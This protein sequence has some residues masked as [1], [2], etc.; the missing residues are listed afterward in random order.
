MHALALHPSAF[1]LLLEVRSFLESFLFE[2]VQAY[3]QVVLLNYLAELKGFPLFYRSQLLSAFF[4]F[5]VTEFNDLVASRSL[6][7]AAAIVGIIKINQEQGVKEIHK[8]IP[9]I[10]LARRVDREIQKFVGALMGFIY[11]CLQFFFGVLVGDVAEHDVSAL[12][13]AGLDAL[14]KVIVEQLEIFA[15]RVLVVV[16][17]RLAGAEVR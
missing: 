13:V 11:F 9:F 2:V 10:K 4:A 8:C 1:S 3:L 7:P 5:A 17:V 14:D 16:V 15:V 12:L 6:L